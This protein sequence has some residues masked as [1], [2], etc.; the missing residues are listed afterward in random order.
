MQMKF[1]FKYF[2][3][4]FLLTVSAKGY[5]QHT[6]MDSISNPFSLQNYTLIYG[7]SD[8]DIH[9]FIVYNNYKVLLL[10][11]SDGAVFVLLDANNIAMDTLF[12]KSAPANIKFWHHHKTFYY[13]SIFFYKSDL[14]DL[15]Y[16]PGIASFSIEKDKFV[17]EEC[18]PLDDSYVGDELFQATDNFKI[19]LFEKEQSKKRDRKAKKSDGS[20]EISE[21]GFAVN[22][23][24]I[25]QR[26]SPVLNS[27]LNTF[28]PYSEHNGKLFVFDIMEN[29]LYQ[30]TDED[31]YIIDTIQNN[32]LYKDTLNSFVSYELISDEGAK[33]LYLLKSQRILLDRKGR[34]K[35]QFNEKQELYRL[36]NNKWE[37]VNAEIPLFAHKMHIFYKKIYAVF[38]MTD[39]R[40]IERKM[41]YFSKSH[42]LK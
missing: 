5:G 14:C 34:E 13:H 28:F 41:L 42:I 26:K 3:A 32:V 37:A 9:D 40:G 35:Q 6:S 24:Y 23:K 33:E 36:N 29:I 21:I 15:D 17:F 11:K 39:E 2:I 16:K 30:F 8:F 19:T 1:I 27:T 7:H 4:G 20:N 10:T 25:L 22:G 12:F 31:N 18:T 38:N